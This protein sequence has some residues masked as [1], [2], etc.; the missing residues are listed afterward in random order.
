[1]LTEIYSIC[2]YKKTKT[3]IT[4]DDINIK[5]HKLITKKVESYLKQNFDVKA[6]F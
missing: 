1:V 4:H 5:S 2:P 6:K 3:V